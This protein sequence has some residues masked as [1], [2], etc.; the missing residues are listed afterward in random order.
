MFVLVSNFDLLHAGR[1]AVL[2]IRA[3]DVSV[4]QG[5]RARIMIEKRPTLDA[6]ARTDELS[7]VGGRVGRLADRAHPFEKFGLVRP[8]AGEAR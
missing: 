1:G 6:A 5:F 3:E 2:G 7:R 8:E 4:E